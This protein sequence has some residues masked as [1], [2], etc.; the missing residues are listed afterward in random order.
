M[1]VGDDDLDLGVGVDIGS[2][3]VSIVVVRRDSGD[4]G[5][6]VRDPEKRYSMGWH[7]L[8]LGM[9]KSVYQWTDRGWR[10]GMRMPV[11]LRGGVGTRLVSLW[12]G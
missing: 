7:G 11:D 1:K 10:W 12:E 5:Y 6:E 2:G 4:A 8:A 3:L 9:S